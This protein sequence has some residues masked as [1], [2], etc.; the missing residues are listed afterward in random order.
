MTLDL[1]LALVVFAFVTSVTPGPNNLMLLASGVNYGFQRSIPHML[2]IGGG[3]TFMVIVVGLGLAQVF[4]AYPVL[5]QILRY[6]GGIFMLWLAWK[7]VNSGPV[8]EGKAGAKPMTFA[9]AALF[10]WVNPKAWVMAI[11]AISTYTPG[12][13]SLWPVL[14]VAGTFGAINLPTV[15]IWTLFGTALRLLLDNPKTLRAINIIMALLLVASMAPLLW[16]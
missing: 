9:Q 13:G 14:M 10:Q 5:H 3:F 12:T 15:S 6:G 1:Y 4:V 16:H 11:S 8:G 2:G 7:I